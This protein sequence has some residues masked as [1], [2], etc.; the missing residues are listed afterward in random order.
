LEQFKQRAREL[1]NEFVKVIE[2][3]GGNIE[4]YNTVEEFIKK[5]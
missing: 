4:T 2:E 3:N 1:Q 5:N